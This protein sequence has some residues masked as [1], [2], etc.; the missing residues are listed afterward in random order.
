MTIKQIEKA[1]SIKEL[2]MIEIFLTENAW[3][4]YTKNM[5]LDIIQKKREELYNEV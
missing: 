2:N 5:Y 3:R 1:K 4:L